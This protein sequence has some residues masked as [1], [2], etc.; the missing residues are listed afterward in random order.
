MRI[1]RFRVDV[2]VFALVL[3]S[4]AFCGGDFPERI[5]EQGYSL[6]QTLLAARESHSALSSTSS[7]DSV[8]VNAQNRL[9]P[10]A[11]VAKVRRP[12]DRA[13]QDRVHI[14]CQPWSC[15]SGSVRPVQ[16][17]ANAEKADLER[18]QTRGAGKVSSPSVRRAARPQTWR[19]R[20]VGTA[21]QDVVDRAAMPLY[22][23]MTF[24][25]PVFEHGDQSF[26]AILLPL[27]R[28]A[29]PTNS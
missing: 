25:P 27:R 22:V 2:A 13:L 11:E 5:D 29:G 8:Q 14:A 9:S 7:I 17:L 4:I 28:S 23:P 19:G 1:C 24:Q 16:V 6:S 12:G 26:D 10:M 15:G 20:A 18:Q 21:R 3:H